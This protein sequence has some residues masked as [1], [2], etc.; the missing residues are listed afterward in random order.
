VGGQPKHYEGNAYDR[1]R[2]YLRKRQRNACSIG[3]WDGKPGAERVRRR[4][5]VDDACRWRRADADCNGYAERRNHSI[6]Y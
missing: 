4:A 1:R 3:D 6:F 5:C 2:H